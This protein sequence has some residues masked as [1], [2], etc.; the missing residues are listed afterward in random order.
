MP[1]V[2]VSSLSLGHAKAWPLFIRQIFFG[3]CGI[4][5]ACYW[6]GVSTASGPGGGESWAR[7]SACCMP[8]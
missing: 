3:T 5:T 2:G 6:C 7:L 1:S 8:M 4:F